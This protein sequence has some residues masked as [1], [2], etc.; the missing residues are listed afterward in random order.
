MDHRASEEKRF[1]SIV[2]FSVKIGTH[3]NSVRNWL[4]EGK[5]KSV[6]MGTRVLIPASELDRIEKDAK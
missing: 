5:I 3:A 4:K 2:E 1:F 6:K